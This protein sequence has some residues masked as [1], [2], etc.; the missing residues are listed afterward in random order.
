MA[1]RRAGKFGAEA[2]KQSREAVDAAV[3]GSVLRGA[4]IL[5]DNEPSERTAR[6]V[7]VFDAAEADV[8]V[9]GK[10]L[11]PDVIIERE[12]LHHNDNVRPMEMADEIPAALWGSASSSATRQ[13]SVR[14]VGG[15]NPLRGASVYLYVVFGTSRHMVEAE[16]NSEG[17][18]KVNFP[19]VFT[20]RAMVVVP[21]G[22]FWPMQVRGP[23]EGMT[24]EC[25]QLPAA[26][27]SLGWWHRRL[28]VGAYEEARG[29]GI[30]VGVADTGV[31]PHPFLAHVRDVGAFID[32]GRH[33]FS[34]GADVESHGSHV[35]GV[36]GARPGSEGRSYG[37]VAPGVELFSARV[38]G[39]NSNAN[40]GDI[41]NAIEAL[42]IEHRVDLIN[43]SLGS[44]SSSEILRD[45]IVDALERGTLCVCAAGN[46][47]GPVKYPAAFPETV[48]I[49][50]L[51]EVGWGPPGSVAA[52]RL[53]Q[54]EARFG[55]DGLYHAHFSCNGPEVDG[56]AP[57]VGV[58]STVPERLGLKAPYAA[59]GG[60]SM[61]SPAACGALA[62]LLA[63][64]G[65]FAGLERDKARAEYARRV[66]A[67]AC[68]SVGLDH[69]YQGQGMPELGRA[70]ASD[71]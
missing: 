70:E 67:R 18:A 11:P 47:N 51:G 54:D 49:A 31:G 60:T 1:N 30:R 61:A 58:I 48:A 9:M 55:Y 19:K 36:V 40:Q 50:A 41:S 71:G 37:G 35:C 68:R 25:P 38:F 3:H 28:G 43:L 17:W 6:R 39:R 16:T 22:G 12:I 63:E 46:S 65:D 32:G 66:F 34:E 33:D 21:V 29:T 2:K 57:G 14:V 45:A 15:E 59:M 69:A 10:A 64:D 27:G 62:V 5:M 4:S 7:V 23:T 53:P 42:S 8:A 24:I 44:E 20:T 26:N 13:L 56:A 52:N